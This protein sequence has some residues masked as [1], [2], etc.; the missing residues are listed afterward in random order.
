[1]NFKKY[2]P[3]NTAIDLIFC[4]KSIVETGQ[5]IMN[6]GKKS[7]LRLALLGI[8]LSIITGSA[9]ADRPDWVE[10]K[11]YRDAQQ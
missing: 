2:Q 9:F 5:L 6:I 3:T 10:R 4:L 7:T 11:Q 8:A 1:M